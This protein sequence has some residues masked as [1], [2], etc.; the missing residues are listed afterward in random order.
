MKFVPLSTTLFHKCLYGNVNSPT[1]RS[2][3]SV[4][5]VIVYYASVTYVRSISKDPITYARIGK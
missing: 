4:S 1:A 5:M 2:R 3:L